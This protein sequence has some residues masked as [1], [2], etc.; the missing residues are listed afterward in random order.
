MK[1]KLTALFSALL[2]L[3]ALFPFAACNGGDAPSSDGKGNVSLDVNRVSFTA[4]AEVMALTEKTSLKDYLD[5]LQKGGEL[6]YGGKEGDY[7]FYIES[8]YGKKA[9]G[10]AFWA[11]YTDL[12]T[13]EGDDF[14]YSNADYGT[15]TVGG[16]TLNSA[17]VGVSSLPCVEGYTYAIVY[18]TY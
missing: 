9:E 15:V 10:N 2:A 5:A 6:V 11:V 12:V 18:S 7:G 8:V 17:S 4:A 16:K 14:V 13:L 3:C 1:K